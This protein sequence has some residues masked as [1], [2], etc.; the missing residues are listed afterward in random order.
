[1]NP[2]RGTGLPA[3]VKLVPSVLRKVP[4]EELARHGAAA[5]AADIWPGVGSR[6]MLGIG[7]E[8]S[9]DCLG[10]ASGVGEPVPLPKGV[11]LAAEPP[12][13]EST[14]SARPTIARRAMRAA[15][16]PRTRTRADRGKG[17]AIV[18]TVS[19]TGWP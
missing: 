12:Q 3:Q 11:E 14:V 16:P 5:A 15:R 8:D 19:V 17:D 10:E 13:P 7:V 6:L 4:E 9:A 1:V 2:V 18:A